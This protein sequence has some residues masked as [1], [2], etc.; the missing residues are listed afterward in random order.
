MDWFLRTVD[1]VNE[2]IGRIFSWAVVLIMLFTVYDVFMRQV[3][4][5]PTVWAFDVTN[6]L[7]GLQF[8]IMAG[9]G[10]LHRVHVSVDVFWSRLPP[11]RQ[12]ILDLVSYAVFFYPFMA[13]L[14]S[15]S[16][17]F[18]ARSVAARETSWGVV[19]MPLYPLKVAMVIA[20]V[21]LLLQGIATTIRLFHE[22]RS[23]R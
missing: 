1:W 20:S 16:Y 6:Q 12:A 10:L 9:F 13:M 3:F 23:T 22:L 2:L 15:Q 11:R 5:A 8:M 17:Q 14:I 21:L 4:S 19:A 7:Y 18:A